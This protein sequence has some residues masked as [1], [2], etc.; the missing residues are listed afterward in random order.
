[1]PRLPHWPQPRKSAK[2]QQSEKTVRGIIALLHKWGVH[3]FGDFRR[4]D[5]E[6]IRARLGSEAV[7]LWERAQGKSTR[8]LK[9]VDPPESF[10][11]NFEFDYEIETAEPLLFILRRFLE[12]LAVRLSGIYLVAKILTLRIHFS[13]KQTYER[14]FEI[15]EPTNRVELLF[16]MLQTH[17]EDFKSEHPIVAVSLEAQPVKPLP[18]QFGLFETSLRNPNQLY[19]TLARLTALLGTDH[20]GTPILEDTHRPDSFRIEPFRWELPESSLPV[21]A[22][23]GAAL[24]RFRPNR[25]IS[26]LLEA[27][28]PVHLRSPEV[29]GAVAEKTGPYAASGNWWDENQW[30]RQ[31]WDAEL[32]NGAI[33]RFHVDGQT[34]ELDGIY[35]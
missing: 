13:N 9:L 29:T 19:E 23:G 15:P 3:T 24:R 8:L 33:C 11:E 34:W 20:A 12:Q 21:Q 35:D 16:R 17:L 2:D 14:L 4:L 28:E 25:S 30:S 31:E 27:G 26:V 10:I 6:Q 7:C 1:M 32:E 22:T 5:K 18:Q